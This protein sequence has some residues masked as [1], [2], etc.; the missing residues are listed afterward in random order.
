MHDTKDKSQNCNCCN[1]TVG[2][3]FFKVTYNP[4][5]GTSIARGLSAKSMNHT[6]NSP[7]LSP[8]A[9]VGEDT[10]TQSKTAYETGRGVDQAPADATLTDTSKLHRK[11]AALQKKSHVQ[12]IQLQEQRSRQGHLTRGPIIN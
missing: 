12:Q 9:T 5:D 2:L 3:S 7:A 8:V 4:S 10:P 1:D 6:E 11:L